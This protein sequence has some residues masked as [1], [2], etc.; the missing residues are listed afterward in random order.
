M[1]TTPARLMTAQELLDRGDDGRQWELVEGV[2]HEVAPAGI[3]GSQ[4]ALR[5]GARLIRFVEERG[6]GAAFGAD[7]GFILHHQPDTVR[8]PDVAFICAD[9]LPLDLDRDGFF[10]GAPDLAVEVVSPTDRPRDV[11]RKVRE[12]LQAGTQLVWVIEP[13]KQHVTEHAPGQE[14]R[15]LT[16]DMA[17]DGGAVLPGFTLPLRELFR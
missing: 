10:D 12:Y 16:G 2:L 4:I 15:V 5:V 3:R 8:S 14:P 9:R 13:R 17:L 7:A 11:S 1:T 6:L